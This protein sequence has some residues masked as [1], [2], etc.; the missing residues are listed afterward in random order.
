MT[1]LWAVY[2][3]C[4]ELYVYHAV[5]ALRSIYLHIAQSIHQRCKSITL[6]SLS[7][8]RTHS[9][10][11]VGFASH[12]LRQ[13]LPCNHCPAT[14]ALLYAQRLRLLSN[15]LTHLYDLF[16]EHFEPIETTLQV[17][18]T[19]TMHGAWWPTCTIVHGACT[20]HGA[21]SL[22]VCHRKDHPVIYIYICHRK[23]H[24]VCTCTHSVMR[25]ITVIVTWSLL[26]RAVCHIAHAIIDLKSASA[27]YWGRAMGI[28]WL[29]SSIVSY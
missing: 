18:P 28:R 19:C 9:Y 2:L 3:P 6:P 29:I 4:C 27:G 20:M 11:H 15:Q 13:P 25:S 17:W 7:L 21:S 1:M 26:S 14:I 16:L 22:Y 12:D 8:S 24:P 23:D 5:L 10:L